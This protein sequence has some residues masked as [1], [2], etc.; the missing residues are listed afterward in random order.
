MAQAGQ[1]L[2]PAA[3]DVGLW[4]CWPG[5]GAL[6]HEALQSGVMARSRDAAIQQRSSW[7]GVGQHIHSQLQLSQAAGVAQQPR[8]QRV[9]SALHV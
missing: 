2:S 7:A 8:Q 4:R 5:A 1:A 3:Q 6:H 9:H